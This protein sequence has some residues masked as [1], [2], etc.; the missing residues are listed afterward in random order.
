VR[1]IE[2][3]LAGQRVKLEDW[4]KNDIIS[5]IFGWRH[6]DSGLRRYRK[7][8]I[9]IPRKNGKSMMGAMIVLIMLMIDGEAGAQI[10]SAA[11]SRD[12]AKVVFRMVKM[13]IEADPT[14]SQKCTVYQNS[15]MF[16]DNFY[17]AVSKEGGTQHGFNSHC[18]IVDEVHVH[19]TRDLIEAHET[20]QGARAQPLM[21]MITTAGTN[22]S[23]VCMEEHD[24]AMSVLKGEVENDSY[25]PIIYAADTDD[26]PFKEDTWKKANPNYGVSVRKQFLELEAKR[27]ESSVAYLNSFKRL[28]LNIWTNATEAYIADHMWTQSVW[29]FDLKEMRGHECIV[30]FDLGATSDLT[31]LALQFWDGDRVTSVNYFFLPEVQGHDSMKDYNRYYHDWVKQGHIIEMPGNVRDDD[32]IVSKILEIV[33]DYDV[34]GIAY[35]PYQAT[36][37]A[38]QLVKSGF[39]ENRIFSVRTG[40]KTIAEPTRILMEMVNRAE[41]NHLDNPVLRWMNNN[42]E[43]KLDNNGNM[44]P[45]KSKGKHKIDGILSNLYALTLKLEMDKGNTGGSYL[46]NSA[47]ILI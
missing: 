5:Q 26:D 37:I 14:L 13:I 23:T 20:S 4:Q 39:D 15:I 38:N 36:N 29:E 16:G 18:T 35:D 34:K 41:F 12:Q 31:A 7:A 8:Y 45:S 6:T 32:W 40:A 2:G 11:G 46:E 43:I 27:A 21:F 28:Y 1:H 30:G 47:P 3:E 22:E 42:V 25:L 9:E 33:Q 44:M 19:K 17:K 10:Y 24:Y